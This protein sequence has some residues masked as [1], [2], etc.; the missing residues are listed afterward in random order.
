MRK[1]IL[2]NKPRDLH[3]EGT[4]EVQRASNDATAYF[5]GNSNT[6]ACYRRLVYITG[7]ADNQPVSRNAGLRWDTDD[8][9]VIEQAGIQVL[10]W[11]LRLPVQVEDIG[12]LELLELTE[13]RAS[14]PAYGSGNGAP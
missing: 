5:L 1:R 7:P 6:F 12:G 13:G 11:R 14:R 2:M 8:V 3:I 9:P 10:S 4:A